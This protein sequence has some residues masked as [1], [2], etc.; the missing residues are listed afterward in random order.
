VAARL[1]FESI[2]VTRNNIFGGHPQEHIRIEADG[3]ALY[4]I[5]ALPARGG[6]PGRGGA[7]ITSRLDEARLTKLRELLEKTNWLT[8]PGGVGPATHTHPDEVTITL[9]REGQTKTIVC[10]GQRPEP[11]ASLLWFFRGIA[12]QEH[13]IYALD[14]VPELRTD[15]CREIR[16]DMEAL[17]GMSSRSL[18]LFDI[19][20]NRLLPSFSR[21]VQNPSEGRDEDLI[22][23]IMLVT[24]VRSEAD[25][26]FVARLKHDRSRNIRTVVAEALANYGGQRAVSD[27]A[28]MA[29]DNDEA[30]WGLI[31]LGDV[32]VPSLLKLTERP[33]GR[34]GMMSLQIARTY[35]EHWNEL[36]MP[37]D[38]RVVATLRATRNK[39]AAHEGVEYFDGFLQQV[40][41]TRVPP[42]GLSA[43]VQGRYNELHVFSREPVR[44]IHGWYVVADDKI[45]QAHAAHAPEPGNQLFLLSFAATPANGT[46]Q[47]EAGWRSA[48]PSVG[49]A[50]VPQFIDSNQVAMPAGATLKVVHKIDDKHPLADGTNPTRVPTEFRT[51]WEANLVKDGET[52]KRILYVARVAPPGEPAESLWPPTTPAL[53]RTH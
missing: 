32:A 15:A 51:L 13:Y 40:A 9:V 34:N 22:A 18:P 20:Y 44:L 19:D 12:R 36:P 31:R 35:L 2:F 5:D 28:E 29:T 23:A 11:Y 39:L 33:P 43:T 7:R 50:A 10:L 8:A 42:A 17:N 4:R 45:V 38:D 3:G 53:A 6:Q 21:I 16:S 27:L 46:V 48:R 14:W 25:F 37:V 41:T 24:Y 49:E 47:I 52:L 26:E 1:G 30:I